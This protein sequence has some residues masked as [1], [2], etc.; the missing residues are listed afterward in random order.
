MFTIMDEKARRCSGLIQPFVGPFVKNLVVATLRWVSKVLPLF[1]I[2]FTAVIVGGCSTMNAGIPRQPEVLQKISFNEIWGYLIR[3]HENDLTGMEPLTD[4]CYFS[5][6]VT[7]EGRITET[8]PRP[9]LAPGVGPAPRIHLVITELSSSALSHF[10]MNPVYGVCPL[11]IEDI[12]R[13]SEG[14]DGIQIDFETVAAGD[15]QY[16]WDFLR[17]LRDALPSAKTLSVALPA[18][19]GP[20]PDAYLYAKIA[21]IVDR[22]MVMAYDEHWSA[23]SPGPVASLP[24]CSA[25]LDY[26]QSI[27][28]NA[29]I[30]MGVP[31]YGRAWQDKK[32]ARALGF[33]NVQDIIA[34]KNPRIGYQSELG[35]YFEYSEN[36]EV[37]IFYDDIRS[38]REKLELYKS[39]AVGSIAFWRI[40]LSPADLW[41]NISSQAP[42]NLPSPGQ[43]QQS[44]QSS[45]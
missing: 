37:R 45:Q 20:T 42:D 31:L 43:G 11:L 28:D 44:I 35:P 39:K 19:T 4:I 22:V 16:F 3:G 29:K 36:V 7:D 12:C 13:V 23:S 40:G 27:M 30:V 38:L 2:V 5:A 33:Q 34:G 8:I 24:W 18:R 21:P 9:S 41:D 15:A 25:V 6:E 14:F 32:L 10:S 1:S 17:A 26:T